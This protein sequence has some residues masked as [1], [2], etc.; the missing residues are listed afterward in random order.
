MQGL[1]KNLLAQKVAPAA[2]KG[3]ESSPA[4]V[5][6]KVATPTTEGKAS[7]GETKGAF[8]SFFESLL[9]NTEVKAEGTESI[10]GT[11]T[12]KAV[13]AKSDALV[14][15]DSNVNSSEGKIDVLLKT[16]DQEK[17][18]KIDGSELSKEKVL[19]ADVLTNINNL[20][21]R[22]PE[23]EAKI[24]NGQ[25]DKVASASSNLDQLLKTLKKGNTETEE[26]SAPEDSKNIDSNTE[27][28]NKKVSPLDFL[29]K[30]TKSN[31]VVKTDLETKPEVV[32][33]LG[34]SS[35]DFL[36]QLSGMKESKEAAK[37]LKNTNSKMNNVL[38]LD[39]E[40]F[41]PKDLLQKQM[42][43]SMKS[44]GQK[45]NLLSD[46]IIRSPK[47]LASKETKLKSSIDELK[48]PDMK[49]GADLAN[50]K[51]NFIPLAQKQEQGQNTESPNAGKVLDLSKINSSNSNEI[52][53]KISDY[54]QQGQVANKDS[55]DL[56]V[57]HESLGQFNIQVNRQPGATNSP[58]EMQI[59]TTTAEGHDFFMKNEIGLMKNL[60]QAGIHLSDLKIVS[61]SG[62]SS[63]AGNDSRQSNNSQNGS[64]A[65]REFMSF[66]SA[67]DSSH[68]SDRRRELWQE[69]RNNQQR[70]GA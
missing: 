27:V 31:D 1:P 66:D 22:T 47:D 50:I 28:K 48:T 3:N 60:S 62:S 5:N 11:R 19:S 51:E 45:Q 41:D 44:Y 15:A 69:A 21:D 43:Q 20:I 12:G 52:I 29:L 33:K 7:A 35:E 68:G 18:K 38:N 34:L 4:V 32:S 63:F 23:T 58:M 57:K 65:G 49:I 67:G 25:G 2:A 56:T 64:Q 61:E 13:I 70:Y 26:T 46:N 17:S 36:G 53:K 59:T 30:E 54:I 10:E 14:A 8:A 37:D 16:K 55:L 24:Q 40:A 42:N 39:G 9:G 6:G